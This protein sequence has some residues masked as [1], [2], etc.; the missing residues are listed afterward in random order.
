MLGESCD[1]C[2]TSNP[3]V[4]VLCHNYDADNVVKDH[5]MLCIKCCN[6]PELRAEYKVCYC[7]EDNDLPKA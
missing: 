1:N 5:M 2:A 3:Y 6:D 7:F 4:T